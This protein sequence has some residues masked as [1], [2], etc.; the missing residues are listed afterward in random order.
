[1][2]PL[3]SPCSQICPDGPLRGAI[4]ETVRVDTK[5]RPSFSPMHTE[6]PL[7]KC[8][9][10]FT[11]RVHSIV[12]ANRASILHA[13]WSTQRLSRR[14]MPSRCV[15]LDLGSGFLELTP[16][17]DLSDHVPDIVQFVLSTDISQIISRQQTRVM[18]VGE[19][20]QIAQHNL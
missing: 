11:H 6:E 1:M 10:I 7:C 20:C 17:N 12:T 4:D 18:T 16:Y 2:T 5:P 13:R 19:Y 9:L 14:S 3:A 8:T 15:F